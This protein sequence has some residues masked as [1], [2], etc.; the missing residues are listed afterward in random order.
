MSKIFQFIQKNCNHGFNLHS[1]I[2]FCQNYPFNIKRDDELSFGISGS[3]LR[4]YA[5][6]INVLLEKKSNCIAVGGPYSNN[7]VGLAQILNEYQIK[8][9]FL[10]IENNRIKMIGN[11]FLLK[12]L[13][14]EEELMFIN[15]ESY[16]DA[17]NFACN[18]DKN[19]FFI[20]E[21][22]A[23]VESI[24]GISTLVFDIL[25]NEKD[26]QKNWSHW[27]LDA[28]TGWTAAAV[29]WLNAYLQLE[30]KISI[31]MIA[32]DANSFQNSLFK[33]NEYFNLNGFYLSNHVYN[34]DLHFPTIGKSFGSMPQKIIQYIENFAKNNGILLDPIY[35]AKTF[36]TAEHLFGNEKENTLII[37]SGGANALHGF[38]SNFFK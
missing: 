34:F 22:A 18:L 17:E 36:Y 24:A 19:T 30:K 29:V 15:K 16:L 1:R 13:C 20:P 6:L 37:H 5:S 31:I 8:K 38:V 3:K 25:K 4:K 11:Y 10:L 23:C 28:G 12:L 9:K 33:V 7:L 27:I 26:Y 35:S 2:S 14:K 32:G 21:G